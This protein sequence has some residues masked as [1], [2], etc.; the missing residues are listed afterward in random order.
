M[1][2]SVIYYDSAGEKLTENEKEAIS[3][4]KT[5]WT[6]CV[7]MVAKQGTEGDRGGFDAQDVFID[8]DR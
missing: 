1:S 8:A 2:F 7:T 4:E 6:L 5:G 3:G